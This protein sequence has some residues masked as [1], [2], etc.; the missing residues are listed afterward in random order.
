[1]LYTVI[2]RDRTGHDLCNKP[3]YGH[4]LGNLTLECHGNHG[5]CS[6]PILYEFNVS[7]WH[8]CSS[9]TMAFCLC[10]FG[11]RRRTQWHA[12]STWYHLCASK[13]SI[14]TSRGIKSRCSFLSCTTRSVRHPQSHSSIYLYFFDWRWFSSNVY[15]YSTLSGVGAMTWSPL[16]CGL[17]TGK[18]SDGVPECSRAAMKVS[19]IWLVLLWDL[20]PWSARY[21]S[22]KS[23]LEYCM[24][25]YQCISPF[26]SWWRDISGWRSEW[27]VRRAA[28]SSLK[29]RS[30]IYWQT[31]WA[32]L[33]HS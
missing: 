11:T 24:L 20:S 6:S 16:A 21:C 14:T 10:P 27:T 17:I 25:P 32:A 7:L 5:E 4:V 29:S 12:S 26:C 8:K 13:R 23:V 28:G 31:D 15:P 1:M 3:G 18:Y 22:V 9:V 19:L 30:S 33:L 2:F